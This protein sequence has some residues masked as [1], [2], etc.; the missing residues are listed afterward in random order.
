MKSIKFS[1]IFLALFASRPAWGMEGD[2]EDLKSFSS[3]FMD[4]P[5][6]F[7]KQLK[8]V[9]GALGAILKQIT[10]PEGKTAE[11]ILCATFMKH[12]KERPASSQFM[13]EVHRSNDQVV[14]KT[15][16]ELGIEY[17]DDHK[18]LFM[19]IMLLGFAQGAGGVDKLAEEFEGEKT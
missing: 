6:F 2:P 12:E 9:G 17:T 10:P 3:D 8:K 4:H 14:S 15:L 1:I 18:G 19:P 16:T 5:D 11:E 13:D 7:S